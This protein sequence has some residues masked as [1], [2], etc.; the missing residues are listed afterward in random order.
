MITI[1]IIIIISDNNSN[2]DKNK[3]NNN[4]NDINK[5]K[6]VTNNKQSMNWCNKIVCQRP[7][8]IAR[9]AF[10]R[11]HKHRQLLH[12][13]RWHTRDCD[14]RMALSDYIVHKHI[15]M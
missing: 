5:K 1:I 13:Q 12:Q 8:P 10:W 6:A 3:N 4:N 15:Y 14:R 11:A 9:K 2:N 7:A